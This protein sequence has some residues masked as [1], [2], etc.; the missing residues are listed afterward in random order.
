MRT[1]SCSAPCDT[2]QSTPNPLERATCRIQARGFIPQR[3]PAHR[4]TPWP[5]RPPP[6]PSAAAQTRPARAPPAARGPSGA[7]P[8]AAASP[9]AA[10]PQRQHEAT[11]TGTTP[12]SCRAPVPPTPGRTAHVAAYAAGPIHRLTAA[13]PQRAPTNGRPAFASGWAAC[14]GARAS[15]GPC[16]CS[17][18]TRSSPSSCSMTC[19]SCT[20]PNREPRTRP[21]AAHR[22]ATPSRATRPRKIS[23]AVPSPALA[24]TPG[25][26]PADPVKCPNPAERGRVGRPRQGSN[27]RPTV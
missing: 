18:P 22:L 3:G 21:H 14:T 20:T 24:R 9:T 7:T 2:S 5:T 15:A 1:W 17:D 6:R 13:R 12:A 25:E 27:L 23:P 26:L 19:S 4:F 11:A 16:T 10:K 8:R